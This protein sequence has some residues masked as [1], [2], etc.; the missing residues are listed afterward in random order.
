MFQLMPGREFRNRQETNMKKTLLLFLC[1]VGLVLV[2]AD[3]AFAGSDKLYL[4]YEVATRTSD[5]RTEPARALSSSVGGYY[6]ALAAN[7]EGR[8]AT[9]GTLNTSVA[10]LAGVSTLMLLQRRTHTHIILKPRH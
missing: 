4:R 7:N 8:D 1:G 3:P 6:L 10:I 2:M 9:A 5:N